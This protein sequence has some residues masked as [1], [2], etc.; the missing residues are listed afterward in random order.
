LRVT[1]RS[2]IVTND[3]EC[4]CQFL[5]VFSVASASETAEPLRG[6]GL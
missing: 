3:S 1:V 2:E 5:A 6:M 4:R